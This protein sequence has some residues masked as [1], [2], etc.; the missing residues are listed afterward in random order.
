MIE[1]SLLELSPMD[2]ASSYKYLYVVHGDSARSPGC[3]VDQFDNK[4]SHKRLGRVV[5]GKVREHV[6]LLCRFIEEQE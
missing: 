5:V 6:L 2:H 4:A 3:Y 1:I